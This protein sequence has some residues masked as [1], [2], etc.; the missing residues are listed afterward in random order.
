MSD[1]INTDIFREMAKTT[2]ALFPEQAMNRTADLWDEAADA[3]EL[4]R[5]ANEE[6]AYRLLAVSNLAELL[7]GSGGPGIQHIANKLH[8]IVDWA[9]EY[10]T[11]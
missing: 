4:L 6:K 9:Y 5:K 11:R 10:D 8:D 7:A 1:T 2:R 3:I